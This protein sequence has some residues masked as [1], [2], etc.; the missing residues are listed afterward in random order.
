M[1]IWKTHHSF[2]HPTFISTN[3]NCQGYIPF[4]Q[5]RIILSCLNQDK[6]GR[7]SLMLLWFKDLMNLTEEVTIHRPNVSTLLS[8]TFIKW[9]MARQ[10]PSSVT[11]KNQLQ[12]VTLLMKGSQRLVLLLFLTFRVLQNP[13]REFW[14]ATTLK[15]LKKPFQTLWHIFAKLKDPVKKEQRADAI[16]VIPCNDC[17][18]EYIG[19]TNVSLVHVWK[20]IKKRFSFAKKEDSALSEY[21]CLTD[22]TIGWDNSK[23]ITSNLRYHQRLCLEA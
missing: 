4:N 17:D 1:V 7:H 11:A 9:Q 19:Q 14:I 10:K 18:N 12:L 16:Y 23:I 21:T 22:H 20:S 15:L 13:S 3:K 5:K 8:S 6:P 2:M